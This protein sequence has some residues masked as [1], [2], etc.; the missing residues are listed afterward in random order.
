MESQRSER[1]GRV[2]AVKSD[3]K[4]G[5]PLSTGTAEKGN[6]DAKGNV[7]FSSP[8]C[9]V[10]CKISHSKWPLLRTMLFKNVF[11]VKPFYPENKTAVCLIIQ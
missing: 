4:K 7:F 8:V 2:S 9:S 11:Q 10:C 5:T 3:N 1:K 6:S